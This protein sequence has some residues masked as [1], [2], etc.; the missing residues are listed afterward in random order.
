ME[1]VLPEN[2]SGPEIPAAVKGPVPFP[3]SN[4]PSVVEPVPPKLTASVVDPTTLPV[5]SV[6]R[7]EEVM[8]GNHTDE[9]KDAFVVEAFWK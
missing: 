4:P 2:E 8:E 7:I 5:V 3:V 6:V 1:S 9:R